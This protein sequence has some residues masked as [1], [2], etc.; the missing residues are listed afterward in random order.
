M[1][2]VVPEAASA[3]GDS[4]CSA[5][6][7]RGAAAVDLQWR[8]PRLHDGARV[9]HWLACPAHEDSLAA[10]LAARGFLLG[11]GRVQASSDLT[12]DG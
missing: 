10:F 9:K 2:Q 7:C 1:S 5:K 4:R 12:S 11:R 6:G 3:P 8:N